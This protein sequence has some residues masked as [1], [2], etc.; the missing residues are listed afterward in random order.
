MMQA[1]TR[2]NLNRTTGA[3]I[4]LVFACGIAHARDARCSITEGRRITFN[5]PCD[6]SP[7]GRDGSFSLSSRRPQGYLLKEISVLSVSITAPGV[8]EVRGLTSAGINSRWG[9]ARRSQ[10]DPACWVGSDFQVCAW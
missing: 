9:E 8:V 7:D 6:F 5:G 10:R 1:L 4:L 3:L 2:A